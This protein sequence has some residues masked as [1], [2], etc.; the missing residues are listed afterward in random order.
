MTTTLFS[1]TAKLVT[2]SE[3]KRFAKIE[4]AGFHDMSRTLNL[5]CVTECN[6]WFTSLIWPVGLIFVRLYVY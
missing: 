1:L 2:A 5:K 4:E 6:A 3:S